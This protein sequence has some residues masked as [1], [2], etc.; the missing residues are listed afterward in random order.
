MPGSIPLVI[1]L[2]S[3]QPSNRGLNVKIEKTNNAD[4]VKVNNLMPVKMRNKVG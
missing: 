3:P 1:K 4:I 2:S